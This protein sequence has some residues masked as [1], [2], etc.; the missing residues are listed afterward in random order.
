MCKK[1]SKTWQLTYDEEDPEIPVCLYPTYY[2]MSKKKVRGGPWA[3]K[4]V[5]VRTAPGILA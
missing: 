3:W 1:R 2:V 5:L 4:W